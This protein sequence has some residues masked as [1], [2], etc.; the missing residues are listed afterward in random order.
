MKNLSPIAEAF[1][2]TAHETKNSLNR[3][4]FWQ[5]LK[6]IGVISFYPIMA[7]YLPSD[8]LKISP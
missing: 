1:I 7:I 8:S 5:S 4:S 2:I 6:L 3:T